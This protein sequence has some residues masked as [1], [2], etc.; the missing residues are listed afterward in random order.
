MA[1]DAV[2]ISV[3]DAD[4]CVIMMTFQGITQLL[5]Q[6][7]LDPMPGDPVSSCF[8]RLQSDRVP[9][10]TYTKAGQQLFLLK[11][12]MDQQQAR[13]SSADDQ[14]QQQQQPMTYGM[15]SVQHLRR[16]CRLDAHGHE[17]VKTP[18]TPSSPSSDLVHLAGIFCTPTKMPKKKDFPPIITLI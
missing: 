14:Q 5:T 4:V 15:I 13:L 11:H 3:D 10:F 2:G 1:A 9:H 6:S 7:L 12:V 18:A 8:R 17:S 16:A